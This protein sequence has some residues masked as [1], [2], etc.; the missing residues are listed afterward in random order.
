MFHVHLSRRCV[1]LHL[2]GMSWRYQG[3]PFNLIYHYNLYISFPYFLFWWSVHWCEW[4]VKVSYDYCVTVNFSFYVCSFLSYVLR[5]SYD[6]C[7]DIYNCYVFLL[8]WS[9]DHCVVSFLISCNL[10]YFKDYF[11]W[12]EDCYSSFPLLPIC[13]EYIFP[14]SHFQSVCVLRSELGLL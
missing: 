1:L 11:V 13:M 7:I 12:Y 14:S 8:N 10:L 9:P 3:D 2:N 6:G 5:C 4:S